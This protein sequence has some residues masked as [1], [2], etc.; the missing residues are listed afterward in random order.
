MW[1]FNFFELANSCRVTSLAMNSSQ[2]LNF[3]RISGCTMTLNHTEKLFAL[4]ISKN[5]KEI[6]KPSGGTNFSILASRPSCPK[7]DSQ[8]SRI[9]S[10][11]KN[12]L[13]LLRLTNQWCWFEESGQWLEN[14]EWTHLVLACGK[15]ALQ[16]HYAILGTKSG[17]NW[18]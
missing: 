11:G 13:T 12:L 16:E 1:W 14:N 18:K 7:F 10:R 4:L 6:M 5:Q 15:P 17:A 2:Q 9:F 3:I 8:H